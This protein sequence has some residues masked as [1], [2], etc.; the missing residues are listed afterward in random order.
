MTVSTFCE[1]SLHYHMYA[2]ITFLV[3]CTLLLWHG[4][5]LETY[6]VNKLCHNVYGGK[7]E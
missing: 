4:V 2:N 1:L 3:I 6:S 5:P 7:T